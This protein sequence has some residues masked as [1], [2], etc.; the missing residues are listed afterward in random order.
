[1]ISLI[2]SLYR[3]GKHLKSYL[4]SIST[5]AKNK[6]ISLEIIIVGNDLQTSEMAILQDLEK[7]Q[8]WLKVI[9]VP[10]ETL[11]ASWNRGV[12]IAKG[13]IVGFWNVDDVRT[14]PALSEA[15]QIF[16]QGAELVYFPFYIKRYLNFFSWSFPVWK[17]EINKTIPEYNS[18]TRPEFMRSMFC[19]PFF[20]FTKELYKKVGPFDEQ[21][22]IAGDFDWCVRATKFNAKMVKVKSIAGEFRVDGSGLSAGANKVVI[23]ETNVVHR[24]FGVFDKLRPED[25]AIAAKYQSDSILFRGQNIKI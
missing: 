14:F 10:R 18:G 11:Y 20:M 21:F 22:K 4:K 13:E 2:T 6:N 25:S 5:F 9:N 19:G 23:A 17:K 12:E 7:K 15:E 16:G 3:P 8:P 1:M 24:R